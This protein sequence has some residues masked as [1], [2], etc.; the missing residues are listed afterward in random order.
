MVGGDG[1]SEDREGEIG[2]AVLADCEPK[3]DLK[4]CGSSVGTAKRLVTFVWGP[5]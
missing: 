3:T 2:G 4:G 5:R 1:I